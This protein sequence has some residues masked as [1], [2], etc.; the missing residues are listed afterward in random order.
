MPTRVCSPLLIAVGVVALLAVSACGGTEIP[1]SPDAAPAESTS[2]APSPQP[3][4][5][6]T[7]D[8]GA[9]PQPTPAPAPQPSPT[10]APAPAP[11]SGN[12]VVINEFTSRTQD[13]EACGEFVELRNDSS[14]AVNISGW[15]IMV[16]RPGFQQSPGTV[17]HYHA[18]E[19]GRVLHSGCHYLVGTDLYSSSPNAPARDARSSCGINDNSGLALLRADG[20][21]ADQVGMSPDSIYREGT[22]LAPISNSA[23]RG[24]YFRTG[25]DTDNN[26]ADFTY[27]NPW[28]PQNSTSSCSIR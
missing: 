12:G 9:A 1:T 17:A 2:P 5:S 27:R 16:H 21:I 15:Q 7:P 14:A 13:G 24:S 28:S 11:G 3:S 26:A 4:P 6:P 19:A 8:P 22:P 10:P 23:G 25:A 18:V 20:S